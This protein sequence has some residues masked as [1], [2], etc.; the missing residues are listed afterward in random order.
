MHFL[1][2]RELSGVKLIVIFF[3]MIMS[4]VIVLILTLKCREA[5]Q[6]GER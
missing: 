1:N 2:S 3:F 6:G 5:G 4:I